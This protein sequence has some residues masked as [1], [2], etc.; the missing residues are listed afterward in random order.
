MISN[1]NIYISTALFLLFNTSYV[2]ASPVNGQVVSGN[3]NITQ[4]SNTTII[5]QSSDKAI[6]NWDSFNV[7]HN[8]TVKFNQLNSNSIVL[9]RVTNGLPTSIYGNI[10]ANGNVFLLNSAGI[11]IGKGAVVNTGSFLAT[12]GSITNENFLKGNYVFNNATNSVINNGTIKVKDSGYAVLLGKQVENNGYIHSRLGKIVLSSGESFRLDMSGNNLI[13]VAIDKKAVDAY[14][15]NTGTL[16]G[17][18]ATIIMSSASA[19]DVIKNAVNNTG[20]INASSISYSGG[21]VILGA[22]GSGVSNTGSID[23]SSQTSNGGSVDI[24][25][26]DIENNGKILA[27]GNAGDI[28]IRATENLV[29]GNNSYISASANGYLNAGHIDLIS[30]KYAT[31]HKNSLTFAKAEYGKGGFIEFSGYKSLNALGKFSTLST[32]GVSGEF[33]L[34]PSDMFIGK[35]PN[36]SGNGGNLNN[37]VSPDGKTYIDINWLEQ[38]LA[39]NGNV[40]LKS[41]EGTGEGNI[42]FEN[43]TLNATDKNLTL[44]A[45][46]NITILGDITLADLTLKANNKIDVSGNLTLTNL[47]ATT[48]NGNINFTNKLIATGLV[49]AESS[50]GNIRFT[51]LYLDDNSKIAAKTI[52][53]DVILAGKLG[54]IS[55]VY[56]KKV[57]IHTTEGGNIKTEDGAVIEA[58]TVELTALKDAAGTNGGEIA[59][60]IN[61]KHIKTTSKKANLTNLY[62]GRVSLKDFNFEEEST[63]YQKEG[64]IDI[65][66]I[67]IKSYLTG[68]RKLALFGEYTYLK[69]QYADF[70]ASSGLEIQ[71]NAVEFYEDNNKDFTLSDELIN[72]LTAAPTINPPQ[73]IT[74][75][76]VDTLI[77]NQAGNININLTAGKD[78]NYVITSRNEGVK[79][80]ASMGASSLKVYANKDIKIDTTSRNLA[81]NS[82]NGNI[83]LNIEADPAAAASIVNITELKALNGT[84]TVDNKNKGEFIAKNVAS[85]KDIKIT[86]DH[87]TKVFVD[88][89]GESNLNLNIDN[90]GDLAQDFTVKNYN[91]KHIVFKG[92]TNKKFKTLNLSTTGNIT[93]PTLDKNLL[94]ATDYIYISANDLLNINT[95]KLNTKKL[96]LELA[97]SKNIELEVDEADI[98]A[99]NL[100]I[101]LKK[102]IKFV[103]MN[104]DNLVLSSNGN[105][106][107]S[108]K[109]KAEFLGDVN[110]NNLT[111][112]LAEVNLQY[113]GI[114]KITGNNITMNLTGDLKGNSKIYGNNVSITAN[115]IAQDGVIF[116]DANTANL[117]A[118]S[119]KYAD[120]PLINVSVRDQFYAFQNYQFSTYNGLG[121]FMNGIEIDQNLYN[122]FVV[123][124][125]SY[126][127]PVEI[128]NISLLDGNELFEEIRRKKEKPTLKFEQPKQ[129][130]IGI[131]YREVSMK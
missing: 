129:E 28:D 117:V 103:D 60:T 31:A 114:N 8:E 59:A 55:N 68:N 51:E 95:L 46:N 80:N 102:D 116:I 85:H 33:L 62:D 1:K 66:E 101:D 2:Y 127:G 15:N 98:I 93:L 109:H 17:E 27:N 48:V 9:N 122:K 64:V 12:T 22:S 83:L 88:G 107:F 26:K 74:A 126:L 82:K 38:Q 105:L 11:L 14:T 84:I 25:G 4:N 6:I 119:N 35:Y 104:G 77:Y 37:Q 120:K 131:V 30:E 113:E 87:N 7:G 76:K 20:V 41:L 118:T 21:H 34:D 111:L 75:T 29:L 58:N 100:N 110:V 92:L 32:Y 99:N 10:L 50:L 5:N 36:L 108:G 91:G 79:T 40:T 63:Y 16:E 56:G 89:S 23:V 106:V 67:D 73:G 130:T 54:L 128:L 45:A 96:F 121:A 125:N 42:T 43:V 97:S 13:G 52:S 39:S 123:A 18:G 124:R 57:I 47:T 24:K 49:K 65:S 19:S 72:K 94:T 90:K 53:G 61:A 81:M 86:L 78:L 112:N 69:N 115:T 71:T 44:D 70:I 3:A